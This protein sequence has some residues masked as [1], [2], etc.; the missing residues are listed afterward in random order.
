MNHI[1]KQQTLISIPC[2]NDVKI[3]PQDTKIWPT[4]VTFVLIRQRITKSHQ[5]CF[6][7]NGGFP[8]WIRKINSQFMYAVGMQDLS[9][10][11]WCGLGYLAGTVVSGFGREVDAAVNGSIWEH[12]CCFIP[13]AWNWWQHICG[14]QRGMK[15]FNDAQE[16]PHYQDWGWKINASF[17]PFAFQLGRASWANEG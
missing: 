14:E 17:C 10:G 2:T 7:L 13:L 8:L 16:A 15:E 12:R 9:C 11:I 6:L 1:V 4:I 5:I 3:P